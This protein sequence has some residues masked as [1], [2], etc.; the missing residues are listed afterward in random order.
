MVVNGGKGETFAMEMVVRQGCPL[1][2][3]LNICLQQM[4]WD[5]CSNP[6]YKIEGL[7]L[8]DGKQVWDQ[9]SVDNTTLFLKG[10]PNSQQKTFQVLQTFYDALG[11][12]LDLHKSCA[13]YIGV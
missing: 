12:K 11:R 1:T 2:P 4:F 6:T 7:I 13:I 3:Y 9:M 5:T 8:L 10:I